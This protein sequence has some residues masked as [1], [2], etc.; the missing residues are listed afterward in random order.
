MRF[1]LLK[2]RDCHANLRFARNDSLFIRSSKPYLLRITL[3]LR[4]IK[5]HLGN[6]GGNIRDANS[7]LSD[8][9]SLKYGDGE[10]EYGRCVAHSIGGAY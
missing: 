3:E 8:L 6:P 9:A 7:E 1:W 4:S 10:C 5:F 2:T